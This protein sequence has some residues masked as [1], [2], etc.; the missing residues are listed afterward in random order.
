MP[1]YLERENSS[2]IE[3]MRSFIKASDSA[4]SGFYLYEHDKL[5]Q[6]VAACK[7]S[8]GRKPLLWGVSFALLDLAEK[9]H[10]DLRDCL[11]F[12]TGGMKGRRKEITRHELHNTLTKEFQ[13]DAIYSEYGMTE[14]L[15]QA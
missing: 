12:E 14:L 5:L 11:V 2:L 4:Y 8:E 1:S 9:H 13:V 10:P 6:D 3:M 15:S 7:N